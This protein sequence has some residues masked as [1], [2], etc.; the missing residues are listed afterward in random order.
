MTV[1]LSPKQRYALRRLGQAVPTILG[2]LIFNF[3]LLHTAPGDLAD[4]LAG[5]SQAATPEF[6]DEIRRRFGLDKPLYI[7]FFTYMGNLLTLDLGYS[8]I[9]NM[10][11]LDLLLQRLPA[12]LLLLAA[13]LIVSVVGGVI[14]GIIASRNVNTPVDY[15]AS[16]GALLFYSTPVFWTGLLLTIVFSIKFGWL[17]SSGFET[18]G[19]GLT[20]WRRALDIGRHLILPAATYSAFYLA[21]YTRIMRAS[22]LEVYTLDF[23]RTA[24]AKGLTPGR[25]AFVHVLR[26]SL[27]PIVT[28]VGMQCAGILGGVVIIESVFGWPGVGRLLFEAVSNRDFNLVLSVL[29]VSSVL[30]VAVNLLLDFLYAWLDPR[31]E[32]R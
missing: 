26:N 1:T 19:A 15:A 6:M 32:I 20:G 28:M 18:I 22:M 30:V 2:V 12:S 17:P 8:H 10:P 4:V 9:Y 16:L 5:Q 29:A 3:I 23:V 27:L 14:L 21:V 13:C 31:I 25:V 7:Q 24:I 11:V